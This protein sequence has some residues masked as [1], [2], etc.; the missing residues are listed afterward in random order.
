MKSQGKNARIARKLGFLIVFVSLCVAMLSA[1]PYVDAYSSATEQSMKSMLTG[2]AFKAAA[3]A[4]EAGSSD[5]ANL[6]TSKAPGYKAPKSYLA[7]VMSTNPDGSVGISTISQ[8]RYIVSDSGK[9]HVVLQLTWGQNALNLAEVGKRGSLFIPGGSVE[10][11]NYRFLIHL[12]T[13]KVEELKYSDEAF[14]A[15]LFNAYYSGAPAKKS[16]YTITCEVLAIEDVG[17]SVKLGLQM[18]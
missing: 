5:L 17:N 1:Q 9:D 10:G 4:I 3:R 16:Q 6:A 13:V 14:N 8:W 11:K 7:H 15:G 18:P 2:E 12:K